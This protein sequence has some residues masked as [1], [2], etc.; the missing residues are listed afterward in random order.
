MRRLFAGLIAIAVVAGVL[1]TLGAYMTGNYE[2]RAESPG[3]RL[4][5]SFQAEIGGPVSASQLELAPRDVQP[6]AALPKAE[7]FEGSWPNDWQLLATEARYWGPNECLAYAGSYDGWPARFDGTGYCSHTNPPTC[8]IPSG[9]P[10]DFMSLMVYGPFSTVGAKAGTVQLRALIDTE[11][12]YDWGGVM[13]KAGSTDCTDLA[14]YDGPIRSGDWGGWIDWSEDL[15]DFPAV[16]DLLDQANVCIAFVF[17]SDAIISN[18]PGFFLDNINISTGA[19]TPDLT[20][21]KTA[22]PTESGNVFAGATITYTLTATNL[23]SATA[24]ATNVRIRDTIGSGLTLSSITPGSGVV[25]G[26]TT[27]PQINCTAAS[28]APGESRTVTIVVTVATTSGTVL[29]GAY[30]DPANAIAEGN[31]DA[32]DPDRDCAAVG[33]GTDVAPAT[34]PDNFDCTGHSVVPGQPSI[35]RIGSGAAPTCTEASVPLEVLAAP[36]VA[37]GAATVDIVYNPAVADPTDWAG[38]P[39]YDMVQCSLAY[40]PNTVRCTAVSA[41]GVSGDSLLADL[42]FHCIGETGECTLLDV[43]VE[44]LADP[45][46]NDL[47]WADDDGEFC[48][49][50]CGDVNC[51]SLVDAVDA[52]FVLQ[53]VVG[54]RQSSDQCPPP[55]GPLYLQAANVNCDGQVD[56]VDALFILQYVVGIRPE[57]CVC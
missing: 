21:T 18:Y 54:L 33:E 56:A 16:G 37:A 41:T 7:N 6:M 29:N 42:T 2:V 35:V 4:E 31:E 46:G 38:G 47:P 3:P 43:Q 14:G 50:G 23:P 15:A 52:L 45:D 24:T 20:I 17:L 34:E 27:P 44:T 10:D 11:P 13:A 25:C 39:A 19:V 40:A 12:E 48:C 28:I 57:L 53:Y 5:S 49:G 8:T 32:D 55:L 26:D 30:V 36:G 22:S 51:D 1:A 9:Y